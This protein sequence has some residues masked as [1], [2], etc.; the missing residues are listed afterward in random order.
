MSGTPPPLPSRRSTL[1]L[2]I[3]LLLLIGASGALLFSAYQNGLLAFLEPQVEVVEIKRPPLRNPLPE[4]A[5]EVD[6]AV[7]ESRIKKSDC[8][9][10]LKAVEDETLAQYDSL[11]AKDSPGYAEGREAARLYAFYSVE[12]DTYEE[13]WFY[14]ADILAQIAYKKGCRDPLILS[15]CDNYRFKDRR[16]ISLKGGDEHLS[17]VDGLLA[18]KYPAVLKLETLCAALHNVVFYSCHDKEPEG[19][20]MSAFTAKTPIYLEKSLATFDAFLKTSPPASVLFWKINSLLE[21]VDESYEYL[22]KLGPEIDRVMADNGT[23]EAVRAYTE[24][25]C[26]I[27]LAWAARG[28]GWANSVTEDGWAKMAKHLKM[29][30]QVI[31]SASEAYPDVAQL[32]GL[33]IT[34]ELGQGTGK[35]RMNQW[36]E[37]AVKIDPDYARPYYRKIYYLQPKWHGEPQ[38]VLDFAKECIMTGRWESGIPLAGLKGLSDLA[39]YNEAFYREPV[40]WAVVSPTYE[41]W[42]ER[43][44]ES[45]NQRT[46]YFRWAV[47]AGKWDVARTQLELLGRWWDRDLLDDKEFNELKAAIPTKAAETAKEG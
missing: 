47:K 6:Y 37:K 8:L 10:Y 12:G 5:R 28:S 4:K 22:S 30:E 45:Y 24:G 26:Q 42:L 32:P 19:D 23:P 43:Y 35:Y 16:S 3:V 27:Y 14:N 21:S 29:A 15:I 41:E 9:E 18:T 20:D 46:R 1:K 7:L 17:H 33:M 2:V 11:N 44:P 25:N 39:E 34:V 31:D 36:F 13:G 38:D 40:L